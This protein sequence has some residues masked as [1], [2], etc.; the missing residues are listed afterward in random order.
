MLP[1]RLYDQVPLLQHM[2]TNLQV[3]PHFLDHLKVL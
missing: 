3:I 2:R 1:L